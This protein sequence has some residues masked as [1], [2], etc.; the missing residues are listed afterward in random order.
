VRSI[1]AALGRGDYSS[2]HWADP[3]IEWVI[4][5]G[6]ERGSATGLDELAEAMR[7]MFSD[8]K[9]VR[10][11]A[12]EYRELDGARVLVL[13]QIRGREKTSGALGRA[14]SAPSA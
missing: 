9:E 12:E 2:T 6:P 14:E 11:E 3:E 1:Y 5:D 4:A 7:R 10:S 8:M 13:F